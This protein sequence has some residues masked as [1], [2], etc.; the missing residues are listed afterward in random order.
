M[1]A[2]ITVDEALAGAVTMGTKEVVVSAAAE[3]VVMASM[4]EV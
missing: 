3:V 1:V 4:L 2:T